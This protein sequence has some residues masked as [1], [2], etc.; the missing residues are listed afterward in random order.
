MPRRRHHRADSRWG[1]MSRVVVDRIAGNVRALRK[2][3]GWTQRQLG[4]AI[5]RDAS[6]ISNVESGQHLSISV[7]LVMLIADAL[8]VTLG[9]LADDGGDGGG[10]G[11]K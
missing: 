1:Q 8:G 2:Q 6:T 3:R 7:G 4:E 10:D 11:R 9:S 5:G